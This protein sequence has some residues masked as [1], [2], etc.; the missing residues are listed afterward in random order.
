MAAEKLNSI[1]DIT[2]INLFRYTQN[3][4]N[5]KKSYYF[6]KDNEIIKSEADRVYHINIV[7]KFYTEEGI[8]FKRYRIVINRN[9]IKRIEK[10][11]LQDFN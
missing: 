6:V 4:D 10:V 3:M 9:G 7:Q 11:K 2:R 5:P 1:V 8:E